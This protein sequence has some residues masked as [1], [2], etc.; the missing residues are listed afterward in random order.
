MGRLT[1]ALGGALRMKAIISITV[2]GITVL[3]D[4]RQREPPLLWYTDSYQDTYDKHWI[5]THLLA[6]CAWGISEHMWNLIWFYGEESEVHTQ[7]PK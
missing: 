1:G 6:L 5:S 7:V 2:P 4:G 3:G